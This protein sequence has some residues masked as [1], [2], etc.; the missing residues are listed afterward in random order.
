[1]TVTQTTVYKIDYPAEEEDAK[2]DDDGLPPPLPE[3]L[4]RLRRRLLSDGDWLSM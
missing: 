4:I 3:P 1:V 2:Q